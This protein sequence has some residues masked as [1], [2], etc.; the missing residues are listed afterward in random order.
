MIKLLLFSGKCFSQRKYQFLW[1]QKKNFIG[2]NLLEKKEN[3]Q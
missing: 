3:F 2:S 1:M